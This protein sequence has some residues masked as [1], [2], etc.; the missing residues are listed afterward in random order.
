MQIFSAETAKRYELNTYGIIIDLNTLEE[1]SI[2]NRAFFPS[3]VYILYYISRAISI[4]Y[5]SCIYMIFFTLKI[6]GVCVSVYAIERFA[7]RSSSIYAFVILVCQRE[8][9]EY[10]TKL[11]HSQNDDCWFL[12]LFSFIRNRLTCELLLAKLKVKMTSNFCT[13]I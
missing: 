1:V 2:G 13:N 7:I 5:N 9:N 3:K 6:A 4:Y 10:L 12:F 8:T 11:I